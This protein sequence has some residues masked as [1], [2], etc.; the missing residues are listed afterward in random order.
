MALALVVLKRNEKEKPISD[1][2]Q[3]LLKKFHDV[4]IDSMLVGLLSLRDI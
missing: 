2:M 3:P 1:A 4:L